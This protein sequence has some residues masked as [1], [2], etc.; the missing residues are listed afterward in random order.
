MIFFIEWTNLT[1]SQMGDLFKIVFL[2][3]IL[4]SFVII[5]GNLF[6]GISFDLFDRLYALHYDN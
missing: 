1:L 5:C 4:L 6:D 3:N 2:K